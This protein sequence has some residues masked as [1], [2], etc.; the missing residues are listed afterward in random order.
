[1]NIKD[2]LKAAVLSLKPNDPNFEP[3]AL[4]IFRYQAEQNPIYKAFLKNLQID[5]LKVTHLEKIPCL[6]IQFFKTQEIVSGQIEIQHVFESS[7]TTSSL[8]AKHYIADLPF[9][10]FSSI[11][12]FEWLYGPLNNYHILA[13]LP[14]YLEKGQSSLVYMVQGFIHNSFSQESGFYLD[15]IDELLRQLEA[16]LRNSSRKILLWGVTFALLDLSEKTAELGFLKEFSDRLIVMETGGMKG[17]KKEMLREEVHD[18]L[19]NAFGVKSIHSEYGMTELLSQAYAQTD[20]LF[21]SAPSMRILL[22]DV[23]DPFS[24]LPSFQLGD[25]PKHKRNQTGGINVFDLANIDSCCFIETQDLGSYS[26]DYQHFRVVGRFD[27]SDIRG[28]NLMAIS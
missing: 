26:D 9:Y 11:K 19:K 7:G 15:N 28:C 1:M 20:G 27:N 23:N 10:E 22:R 14:N 17:R 24:Y 18:K 13:L 25:G 5:P 3:L 4:E 12:A 8:N 6:P 16:L 21:Q 2:E